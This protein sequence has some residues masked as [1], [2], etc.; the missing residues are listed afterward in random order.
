MQ[1]YKN[2]YL[3]Y[4]YIINVLIFQKA[5]YILYLLSVVVTNEDMFIIR[6]RL[7]IKIDLKS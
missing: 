1:C 4:Y 2:I 5:G 6:I 7:F 3:I